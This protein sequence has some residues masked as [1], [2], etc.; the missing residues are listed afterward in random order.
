MGGRAMGRR[1]LSLAR[2]LFCGLLAV[3]LIVTGQVRRATRKALSGDVIT[4]IYFHK[5]NR[6]LFTRCI[7]WLIRH[8]YTFISSDELIEI[9]HHKRP[10]PR[11]A[12]WLSLDDG[13]REWLVDLLPVIRQYKVPI[14]LFLPSGIVAGEGLFPWLHDS[15]YSRENT[16]VMRPDPN[17]KP[18][19]ECITVEELKRIAAYEEIRIG[20][21]SVSHAL[22]VNCKDEKLQVEIGKC[23]QSLEL[24]TGET[25]SCF[26]YPEGRYDGR[27]RQPLHE[28]GYA[29]AV[30]TEPAFISRD[31]DPL[32]VPRFCVPDDVTLSEAIC[33]MVGI[34]RPVLDPIK[35]LLHFKKVFIELRNNTAASMS[36]QI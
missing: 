10:F 27:E 18:A 21:H 9:L 8:G 1:G 15:S 12:V 2:N 31:T 30:T 23:K 26:S 7:S 3:F 22:T 24:W 13:Y 25:V 19:R 33:N 14:T 6:R 16:E 5:P 32:L 28:F 35:A 34:W 20:G 17:T 36:E 11:G 4:A 29:F